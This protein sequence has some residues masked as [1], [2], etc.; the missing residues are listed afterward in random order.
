MN[1]QHY[2]ENHISKKNKEAILQVIGPIEI[3]RQEEMHQKIIDA[4]KKSRI[5]EAKLACE[6]RRKKREF[7]LNK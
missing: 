3:L 4:N 7:L 2:F 6:Q 5:E 1:Q